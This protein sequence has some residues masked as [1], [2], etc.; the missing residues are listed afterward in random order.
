M[1]EHKKNAFT[2]VELLGVLVV[3]AVMSLVVFPI[4]MN[5]FKNSKSNISAATKEVIY[6][7]ANVYIE[8]NLN[9]YPK[10]NGA[11]YCITLEQLVKAEKL[12][13]PLKD[14]TT[15]KEIPSDYVVK[16]T[17]DNGQFEYALITDG[18]CLNT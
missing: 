13:A 10:E 4:I 1:M 14:P 17:V 16:A 8:D 5:Q 2:L 18:S 15:G 6:H 7:A 11:S 9:E 3:I 12:S